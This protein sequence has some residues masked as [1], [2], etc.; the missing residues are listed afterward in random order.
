MEMNVSKL[1]LAEVFCT[2]HLQDPTT[3]PQHFFDLVL[4][5]APSGKYLPCLCSQV[6]L[7]IWV[8]P[9]FVCLL[10]PPPPWHFS[11]FCAV[12]D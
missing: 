3:D 4:S 1:V 9:R 11:K 7:N 8:M 12:I 5:E 10:P 6:T 2:S